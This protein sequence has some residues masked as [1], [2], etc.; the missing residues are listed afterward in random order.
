MRDQHSPRPSG[1][2]PVPHRKDPDATSETSPLPRHHARRLLHTRTTTGRAN[3]PTYHGFQLHLLNT[4]ADDGTP[5]YYDDDRSPS[6]GANVSL[7]AGPDARG[8][9]MPTGNRG[10][11]SQAL[12][13]VRTGDRAVGDRDRL[14][15]IELP[16]GRRQSHWLLLDLPDGTATARG[17]VRGG[18]VSRLVCGPLRCGSEH[19][20]RRAALCGLGILTLAALIGQVR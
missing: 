15:R 19:R 11:H 7:T 3:H 2:T 18:W 10:S 5:N 1:P 8:D 16:T 17:S 9:A 14:A 4:P 13:P 12:G 6:S 20:F